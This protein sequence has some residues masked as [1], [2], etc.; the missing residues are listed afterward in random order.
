MFIMA[1]IERSI[2][3]HALK[4]DGIHADETSAIPDNLNC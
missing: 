2:C 3:K 4:Y 1:N